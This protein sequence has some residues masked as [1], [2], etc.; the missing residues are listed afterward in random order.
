MAWLKSTPA[1]LSGATNPR[2]RTR[3]VMS[4][5]WFSQ[6]RINMNNTSISIYK[7]TLCWFY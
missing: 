4:I 5:F 1:Y 3:P 7:T 6:Y 2:S